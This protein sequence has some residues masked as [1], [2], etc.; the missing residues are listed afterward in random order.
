MNRT[1]FF[2]SLDLTLPIGERVE[3][4]I[5]FSLSYTLRMFRQHYTEKND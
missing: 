1:T 3:V 2:P 4:L 5:Y